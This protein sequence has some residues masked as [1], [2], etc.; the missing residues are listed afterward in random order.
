MTTPLS[1]ENR[2]G[3]L[4]LNG[5]MESHTLLPLWK[6]RKQAM[7]N[8]SAINTA[9]VTHIDSTGLALLVRLGGEKKE[10]GEPIQ[11]QGVSEQFQ[12]LMSLYGVSKEF[13]EV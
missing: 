9:D 6:A 7:Q 1:W 13:K 5:V 10:A 8:V 3:T 2:D 12:T 4:F 11:L